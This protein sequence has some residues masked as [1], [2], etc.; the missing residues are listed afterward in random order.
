M[1]YTPEEELILKTLSFYEE[2]DF[3]KIVLDLDANEL[4]NFPDLNR[5]KIEAIL[6]NFAKKKIITITTVNEN[7]YYKKA[8]R[9]SKRINEKLV[10]LSIL[11]ALIVTIFILN[12]ISRV[13][14]TSEREII[15]EKKRYDQFI[16]NLDRIKSDSSEFNLFIGTSTWERFLNPKEFDKTFYDLKPEGISYNLSFGGLAGYSLFALTLDLKSRNLNKKLNYVFLEFSIFLHS[17]KFHKVRK[18]YFNYKF[19]RVF[20]SEKS[21]VEFMQNHPLNYFLGEWIFPNFLFNFNVN[22]IFFPKVFV[23]SGIEQVWDQPDFIEENKW[24]LSRRGWINFNREKHTEPYEKLIEYTEDTETWKKFLVNYRS[25]LGLNESFEIDEDVFKLFRKSIEQLK[26][27]SRNV[28]VV[29]T[30]INDEM[31]KNVRSFNN[32]KSVMIKEIEQ[33]NNVKL[34]DLSYLGKNNRKAFLDPFHFKSEYV[35]NYLE[36]IALKI[37]NEQL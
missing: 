5:E 32:I 21:K 2:M 29:I 24:D 36:K 23:M 16:S 3:Q 30:P 4:K 9:K 13:K 33:S 34:I 28:V 17:K 15:Q 25:T 12:K 1:K 19:P 26:L 7:I 10:V 14:E 6:E 18:S 11:A 37:K 27:I 8:F 22:L 31:I 20:L 35:A